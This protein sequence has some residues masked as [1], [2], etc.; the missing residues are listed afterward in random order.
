MMMIEANEPLPLYHLPWVILKAAGRRQ[1]A[2]SVAFQIEDRQ[3]L[4]LSLPFT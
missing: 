4:V 3:S 2:S 1:L